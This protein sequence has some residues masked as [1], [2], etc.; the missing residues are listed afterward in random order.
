M[1]LMVEPIEPA[2]S[3]DGQQRRLVEVCVGDARHEV[4]GAGS[5]RGQAHAGLSGKASPD[6][7]DDGSAL[8]VSAG[9]EFD[10]GSLERK[11]QIFRLFAGTPKM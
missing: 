11:E 9:H 3:R 10:R 1:A 5:Q 7:G 2:L 4:G 8:L 6:V